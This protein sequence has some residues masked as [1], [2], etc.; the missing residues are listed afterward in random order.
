MFLFLLHTLSL[1]KLAKICKVGRKSLG[2]PFICQGPFGRHPYFCHIC[3]N[4]IAP[5]YVSSCLNGK[6]LHTNFTRKFHFHPSN[7]FILD[8]NLRQVFVPAHLPPIKEHPCFILILL[9]AIVIQYQ[10]MMHILYSF[11][12][13][14]RCFWLHL[15][16]EIS[17]GHEY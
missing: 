4:R 13:V 7:N 1:A 15:F 17:G 11:G 16:M 6:L 3:W 2:I 5:F 10:F 14:K 9:F 12:G 8:P